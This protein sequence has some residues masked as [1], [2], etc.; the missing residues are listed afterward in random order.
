MCVCV[1]ADVHIY[2]CVTL[3]CRC[4][5]IAIYMCVILISLLANNRGVENSTVINEYDTDTMI[6]CVLSQGPLPL[7]VAVDQ[8]HWS[9]RL[10]EYKPQGMY[11]NMLDICNEAAVV[12]FMNQ[13]LAREHLSDHKCKAIQCMNA[14]IC[15]SNV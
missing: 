14:C 5:Y 6:S 10:T 9:I 8:F 12:Y 1:H 13:H 11:F 15:Y 7:I 4:A 2:M 3:I